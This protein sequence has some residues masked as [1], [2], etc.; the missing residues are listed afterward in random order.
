ME[1]WSNMSIL[2]VNIFTI[3]VWFGMDFK[4]LIDYT[5]TKRTDGVCDV[6]AAESIFSH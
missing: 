6:F 5:T 3:T 2:K 1:I 4:S